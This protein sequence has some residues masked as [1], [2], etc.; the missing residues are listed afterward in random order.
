MSGRCKACN[1]VLF[2]H[3][4]TL[5]YPDGSYTDVCTNCFNLTELAESMTEDQYLSNKNDF[6]HEG[7]RSVWTNKTYD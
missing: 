2:D 5:K 4:L 7:R 3:E 1:A 6:F